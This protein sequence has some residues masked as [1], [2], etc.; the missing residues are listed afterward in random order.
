MTVTS[1]RA[2]SRLVA[3]A[4]TLLCS[5]AAVMAWDL[6]GLDLAIS[7][8][9]GTAHGFAWRDHWIASEVMHSHARQVGWG[10]L[11][12]L[13]FNVWKPLPFA[14][15]LTR[16]ERLQWLVSTL[17][18]ACIIPLVKLA[19]ATSCPWSLAEFGGSV[20]HYVPHWALGIK[21]EGPGHCFPSGH[22]S[23]AFSFFTGWFALRDRAPRIARRWLL[24]ALF[25]GALLGGVQVMRG[26]HY[27]SHPMWTAW[28]CWS[29]SA[30]LAHRGP[31]RA[32][33]PMPH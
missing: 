22:A 19:S 10:L 32:W 31:A 4:I 18:C 13:A 30:L 26:A 15:T 5:L 12:L 27:V 25:F 20:A 29:I 3:D 24:A 21:D 2:H 9:F 6:S 14:L 23:T 28:I 1:P 7:R 11:G 33:V 17:A 8:S 16:Q